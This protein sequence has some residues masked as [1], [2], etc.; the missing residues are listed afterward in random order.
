VRAHLAKRRAVFGVAI[1]AAISPKLSYAA[2]ITA[3]IHLM[4]YG[5]AF[6]IESA[7]RIAAECA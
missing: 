5:M 7:D 3:D 6:S 1:V 4:E 2:S